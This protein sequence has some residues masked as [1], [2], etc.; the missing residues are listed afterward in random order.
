MQAVSSASSTA[1]ARRPQLG[2]L[3][4][5]TI[6]ALVGLALAL[7]YAQLVLTG[8]FD[9]ALT[10]FAGLMLAGGALVATGWR[11]APLAGAL[12]SA[13]VVAGNSGAV[14]YDLTHPKA[15]HPFA[16]M[17]VAVS[18]SLIGGV[19]GVWATIQNYRTP[20]RRAPRATAIGLAALAGLAGGALLMGAAPQPAGSGVSPALL[21]SLPAFRTP[22]MYFEQAALHA[23]VGETVALRFENPH[24][25]PHAF[26]VDELGVDVAIAPGEQ[27]LILFK[28]EQPGSYTFYCSVPGH[29][30]AGMLGR[31]VVEQ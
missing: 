14:I 4:W 7:G 11:W 16:F 13:L 17:V 15:Y 20:G 10:I 31:L 5:L 29:R 18:F 22:G 2:G 9:I 28:P 3:S 23:T 25:A 19:G 12:L 27:G 30:E 26:R 6:G 1:S 24:A 21:A 8:K